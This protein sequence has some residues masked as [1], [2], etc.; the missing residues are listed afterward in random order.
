[1]TLENLKN[2]LRSQEMWPSVRFKVLQHF[3]DVMTRPEDWK[4]RSLILAIYSPVVRDLLGG[5]SFSVTQE[6]VDAEQEVA[7]V[8]PL[9]RLLTR[10][11]KVEKKV[12]EVVYISSYNN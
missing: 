2:S 5:L 4:N 7:H 8:P 1:M 12:S 9:P 10:R 11:E 6:E 3:Q